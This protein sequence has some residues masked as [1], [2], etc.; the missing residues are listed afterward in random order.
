MFLMP[1]HEWM[2]LSFATADRFTAW[3]E[4]KRG[5]IYLHCISMVALSSSRLHFITN[6]S[7]LLQ[8]NKM[9]LPIQI[10][11]LFTLYYSLKWKSSVGNVCAFLG[12]HTQ[13]KGNAHH[14]IWYKQRW[15][16]SKSKL[17]RLN[18]MFTWWIL[19]SVMAIVIDVRFV[20]F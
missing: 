11:G 15:P 16:R 7:S 6:Y 3:I 9:V 4:P 2:R 8:V 17:K 19:A 18:S 13:L 14:M 20:F 12:K 1:E 5:G 10:C